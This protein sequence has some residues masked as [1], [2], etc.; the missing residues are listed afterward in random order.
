M[1]SLSLFG[2]FAVSAMLVCYA[3]ENRS[4]WFV[5]SRVYL[6]L[7]SRRVAVWPGGGGLVDCGH[8]A[9]DCRA[10]FLIHARKERVALHLGGLLPLASTQWTAAMRK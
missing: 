5:L 9:L 10:K 6:R 3:L 2:L 1:N 7:S 4:H 8:S